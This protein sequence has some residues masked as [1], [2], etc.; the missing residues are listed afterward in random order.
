[1]WYS[2]LMCIDAV[3]LSRDALLYPLEAIDFGWRMT[4]EKEIKTE[5]APQPKVYFYDS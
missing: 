3:D 2:C 1:M 5:G 4:I